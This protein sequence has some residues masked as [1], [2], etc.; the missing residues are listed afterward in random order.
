M[1]RLGA[2]CGPSSTIEECGR[3][4]AAGAFD[5][6]ELVK[7]MR[8]RGEGKLFDEE[9]LEAPGPENLAPQLV[10]AFVEEGP[11]HRADA[12]PRCR[13]RGLRIR[14]S[15]D[16]WKEDAGVE[17]MSQPSAGLAVAWRIAASEAGAAGSPKI[18]CPHLLMGVLSLDKVS[19][20]ILKDLGLAPDQM[21]HVVAEQEA[22]YV[23]FELSLIH[24]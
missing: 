8:E 10:R 15:A 7:L 1:A 22:I 24:I 18:E 21:S 19:A 14:A 3:R 20:R 23:L 11:A 2:R 16:A 4:L 9:R 12:T 6:M 5:F 17:R 13:P